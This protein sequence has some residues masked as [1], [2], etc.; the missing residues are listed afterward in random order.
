MIDF[1]ELSLE[2]IQSQYGASP[3]I[4]GLVAA[5][6]KEIDPNADIDLLYDKILNL[7]TAEG[8]GLDIWGRIVAIPRQIL[9]TENNEFFGFSG[10]GLQPFNQAPFYYRGGATKSYTLTDESYR[11]LIYYKAL[12]NI[13]DSTAASQNRLLSLLFDE[14]VDVLDLQN[15][16]PRG[17]MKIRVVFHFYL[18]EYEKAILNNYGLLNRGAGVGWEWYQLPEE[19]VF[20]FNGSGLQPFNQ[21]NFDPYGVIPGDRTE[22]N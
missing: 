19:T 15:I 1:H 11:K 12:S 14:H 13:S 20:G 6:A 2:T 3:H 16:V 22:E 18:T 5:F 21:G 4:K 10:S 8:I 7:D 9:V 17:V